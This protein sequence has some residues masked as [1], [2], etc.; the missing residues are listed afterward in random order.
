MLWDTSETVAYLDAA[1]DQVEL[2]GE[3]VEV[4]EPDAAGPQ[5]ANPAA[6]RP[7]GGAD[8]LRARSNTPVGPGAPLDPATMAGNTA[9]QAVSRIAASVEEYQKEI[10]AA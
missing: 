4:Y 7:A 9:A 1:D 2:D 3:D 8:S 6:T 10:D 5:S